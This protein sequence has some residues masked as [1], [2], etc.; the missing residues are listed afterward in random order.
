MR[1]ILVRDVLTPLSQSFPTPDSEIGFIH[2]RLHSFRHFFCSWCAN[3]NVPEQMLMRW[4]GHRSSQMARRYYHLHDEESQRH[5]RR[6]S[7]SGEDGGTAAGDV[8]GSD[9]EA[10][11]AK[12]AAS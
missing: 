11:S 8:E 4:L 2:G 9:R 5:M 7:L 1:N 6:L 3:K 12:G 10:T